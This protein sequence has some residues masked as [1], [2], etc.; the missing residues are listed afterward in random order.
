MLRVKTAAADPIASATFFHE[1]IQAVF[2]CLL[3]V[4]GQ[5]MMMTAVPWGKCRRISTSTEGQFR[6]TLHARLLV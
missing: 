6:P 5:L 4:G 2:N 3:R 1:T